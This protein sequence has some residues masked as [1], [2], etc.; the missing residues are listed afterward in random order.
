MRK[1]IGVVAITPLLVWV[2]ISAPIAGQAQTRPAVAGTM[3]AVTSAGAALTASD[4]PATM[5]APA[6]K[7][8]CEGRQCV[9][10]RTHFNFLQARI[11]TRQKEVEALKGRISALESRPAATTDPKVVKQLD[12]DRVKL[13]TLQAQLDNLNVQLAKA[14]KTPA[15][16]RIVPDPLPKW[17]GWHW[18]ALLSV[19][20]PA[21]TGA[22]SSHVPTLLR[23]TVFGRWISRSHLG[24]EAGL[25]PG[26]WF[27][28]NTAPFVL[29][30]HLFGVASWEHFGLF[31][32]PEGS[33]LQSPITGRTG[34][35]LGTIQGGAEVKLSGFMLRLI[36]AGPLHSPLQ[37]L[38][39]LWGTFSLGG[40]F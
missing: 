23:A 35:F 39:G 25:S 1:L 34:Y 22:K 19:G 4:K 6:K 37:R 36:L 27:T 38:S 26:L 21:F 17:A 2:I 10:V 30:G 12:E 33:Y 24:V 3:P 32:G 28:E 14:R 18:G 20:A 16:V 29:S 11:N 8:A 15:P 9:F 7:V 31:L 13:G 40:Y 5:P